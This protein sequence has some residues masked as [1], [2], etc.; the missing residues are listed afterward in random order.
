[1]LSVVAT[2]IGNLG[3]ITLRAIETLT[4]ADAIVCEDTR[5]TGNLLKQLHIPKKELISLHGY[6]SPEKADALT[7]R[8]KAGEHMA[9]VSDAGTPGISDPGYALVSRVRT[10]GVTIEVVPGPSALLAALSASGL[11]INQFVYLGFPPLKKGRQTLFT[12]LPEEK[13]TVVLYESVHRIEKTLLELSRY[14]ESQPEREIVI[15]R[16]LT[17]MHEELIACTIATLQDTVPTFTK[18]GEF[19]IVIGPMR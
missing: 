17:K 13:R 12:S 8:M 6:S 9:L 15:A 18:K 1:M 5:V 4:K 7:A 10:A 11:P 3:D 2:P 19:V 16:E 14:L